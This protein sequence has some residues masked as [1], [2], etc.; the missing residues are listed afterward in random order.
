MEMLGPKQVTSY[1]ARVCP[2]SKPFL[3]RRTLGGSLISFF[4]PVFLLIAVPFKGK[5]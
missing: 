3:M 1:C 4:S 2:T 5:L